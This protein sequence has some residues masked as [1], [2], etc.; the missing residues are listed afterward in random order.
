MGLLSAVKALIYEEETKYKAGISQQLAQKMGKTNNFILQRMHSEKNFFLNG[1]Y[2]VIADPQLSIDGLQI[3]EFDAEIFNVWMFNITPG[4]SGTTELDLKIATSSGGA[5]S[6]I[7]TTTPK[8]TSA[9]A[10]NSWVGVG[11]SGTGLTAPVLI[12]SPVNVTAGSAIRIDKIQSMQGAENCGLLV[13]YR[14]R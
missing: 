14:P 5:F 2:W 13:H 4:T 3:F 12:S 9:A 1:P 8:I 7:F 11:G 6:S 10:A